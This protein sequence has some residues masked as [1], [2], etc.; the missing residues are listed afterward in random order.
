[1]MFSLWAFGYCH[2][3][4]VLISYQSKKQLKLVPFPYI[5]ID[6]DDDVAMSE[7]EPLY[8]DVAH[9]RL[10]SNVSTVS[11]NAFNSPVFESRMLQSPL[12]SVDVVTYL[13]QQH[14]ILVLTSIRCRSWTLMAVWNLILIVTHIMWIS[15]RIVILVFFNPPVV[16]AT[17]GTS[18]FMHVP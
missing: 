5:K 6:S 17:M 18:I 15:H 16:F 10:P 12:I 8:P 13:R 14:L 3:W 4:R 9:M 11:S 7:A 2:I 1:M